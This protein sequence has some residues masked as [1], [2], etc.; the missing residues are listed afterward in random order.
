MSSNTKKIIFVTYIVVVII[1][2]SLFSSSLIGTNQALAKKLKTHNNN[3][4][5]QF[6]GLDQATTQDL[7]CGPGANTLEGFCSNITI[8]TQINRDN[9]ALG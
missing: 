5:S 1:I 3:P 6:I 7:Q 9:N 2:L 4:T 8:Q